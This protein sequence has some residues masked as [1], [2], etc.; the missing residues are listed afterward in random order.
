MYLQLS[1]TGLRRQNRTA[2]LEKNLTTFY[3]VKLLITWPKVLLTST[4]QKQWKPR[5][6]S[7]LQVGKGFTF[8]SPK[9]E[10]TQ[11]PLGRWIITLCYLCNRILL[12]NKV[13]WTGVHKN[14]EEGQVHSAKLRKPYRKGHTS[15]ALTPFTRHQK[16]HSDRGRPVVTRGWKGKGACKGYKGVF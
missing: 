4:Y 13:E 12:S 5:P 2:T 8:N 7:D 6:L 14:M 11:M 9:R 15:S 1:R 16:S 10:R 3:K